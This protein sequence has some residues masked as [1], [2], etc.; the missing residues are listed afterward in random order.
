MSQTRASIVDD[1]RHLHLFVLTQ[2]LLTCE[3]YA[4]KMLGSSSNASITTDFSP[5]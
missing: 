4:D 1:A 5:G 3:V 2:S